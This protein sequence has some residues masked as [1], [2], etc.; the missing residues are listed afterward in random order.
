M[1]E[2]W[3]PSISIHKP[4]FQKPSNKKCD[5][6]KGIAFTLMQGHIIHKAG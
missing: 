6:D 1:G 5:P 3:N 4:T 2:K